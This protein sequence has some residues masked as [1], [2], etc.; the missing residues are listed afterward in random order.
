MLKRSR[1]GT[2]LVAATR[3][4]HAPSAST[5]VPSVMWTA[6]ATFT[7]VGPSCTSAG[8]KPAR[9]CGIIQ[10]AVSATATAKA[11]PW[12][13]PWARYQPRRAKRTP[14]SRTSATPTCATRLRSA[15]NG[16]L[17][18][19]KPEPYMPDDSTTGPRLRMLVKR[20]GEPQPRIDVSERVPGKR[21]EAGADLAPIDRGHLVAQ[22]EARLPE[23]SDARRDGDGGQS[24]PGLRLRGR[25]RDDDE[26]APGRDAVEP[27]V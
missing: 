9:S 26:R 22:S 15:P 18:V 21:P 16:V 19:R 10:T 23:T 4:T 8:P 6:T 20:E 7:R 5:L 24:S 2:T 27:V 25:D 13:A 1:G 12:Q 3:M 11:S 14:T 17:P